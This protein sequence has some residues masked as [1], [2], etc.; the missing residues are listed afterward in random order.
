MITTLK[1]ILHSS[2]HLLYPHTCDGCGSD[3][4]SSKELLCGQCIVSLPNTFFADIADNLVEKIF[5]GRLNVK[6]AYSQLYFNKG[7][8]VQQLIHQLKYKG[9]KDIGIYLGKLMGQ[10][11]LHNER[12]G[13]IDYLVP[14]PLF[15]AKEHK[16]GYNQATVLCNGMA[17]VLNIPVSNGN[18][19]RRRFTQ[20]QTRKQRTER[21]ENVADS[22]IINNPA[23]LEGK[24]LL[25]VDDVV[26]TGATLDACGNMMLQ[27][28]AATLSIAT[29]A[30]AGK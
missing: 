11:L 15:A 18:V 20:T 10:S 27:V 21:W 5:T 9:N 4:L 25:L 22:F 26:T 6:A 1:N 23:V 3:L 29:L 14:L 17:E 12:F 30:C 13:H 2:L 19:A 8:L 28:P 24:H 7:A 16:R